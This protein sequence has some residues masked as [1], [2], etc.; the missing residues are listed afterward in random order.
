MSKLDRSFSTAEKNV[1]P[2]VTA[3]ASG[4]LYCLPFYFIGQRAGCS[5]TCLPHI[6]YFRQQNPVPVVWD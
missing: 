1:L 3:K 5:P 4:S 2:F 6:E